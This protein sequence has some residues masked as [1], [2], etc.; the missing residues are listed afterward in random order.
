MWTVCFSVLPFKQNYPQV[1]WFFVTLFLM[2]MMQT[3]SALVHW[4]LFCPTPLSSTVLEE[5]VKLWG[6]NSMNVTFHSFLSDLKSQKNI[7]QSY[8]GLNEQIKTK[9]H[10]ARF[11]ILTYSG[12]IWCGQL[13]GIVV[14]IQNSNAHCWMGCH[15]VII[16]RR[17]GKTS[18]EHYLARHKMNRLASCGKNVRIWPRCQV[19]K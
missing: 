4:I 11:G 12:F 8:I 7:Y 14:D 3:N 18:C 16:Y 15:S 19:K 1:T 6:Y 5:W 17:D 2:R 9:T 13:R 10:L